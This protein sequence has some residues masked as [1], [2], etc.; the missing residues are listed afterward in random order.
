[1]NANNQSLQDEVKLHL[2]VKRCSQKRKA[3]SV[4]ALRIVLGY[5]IF[6]G[7]LGIKNEAYHM[8]LLQSK[9]SR[10]TSLVE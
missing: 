9:F 4:Q 10:R 7:F 6:Q 5:S 8:S 3:N 1:M 2:L